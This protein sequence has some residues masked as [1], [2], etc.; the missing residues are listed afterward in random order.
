M[1]KTNASFKRQLSIYMFLV[2][3]L[4]F[5]GGKISHAE[6]EKKQD[7]I[8][9]IFGKNITVS[10]LWKG[11]PTRFQIEIPKKGDVPYPALKRFAFKVI[12][13]INAYGIRTYNIEAPPEKIRS[14]ERKQW[15]KEFPEKI[16][17][18][19]KET[20][21]RLEVLANLMEIWLRDRKRGE[22]ALKEAMR[23][24]PWLTEKEWK[25]FYNYIKTPEDLRKF[26][27]S[28]PRT[29]EEVIRQQY[30][31][32]SE[33]QTKLEELK[34]ILLLEQGKYSPI[35]GDLYS[36]YKGAFIVKKVKVIHIWYSSAKERA[37]MELLL[38]KALS[39]GEIFLY[40][41]KS[42]IKG[43]FEET[44]F[45]GSK[46]IESLPFWFIK[47]I[48]K[49]ENT[50]FSS[51]YPLY[52]TGWRTFSKIPFWHTFRVRE[53]IFKE[54]ISS[55]K[56][57][58]NKIKEKLYEKNLDRVYY[59]WILKEVQ[60]NLTIYDKRFQPALY[61]ITNLRDEQS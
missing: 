56:N 20:I 35:E 13:E 9:S 19:V 58:K 26:R 12:E 32:I 15:K 10:D 16:N 60:R 1:K 23:K 47:G 34:K 7:V 29:Q 45:S 51:P 43:G 2:I 61:I 54:N 24:N 57:V 11:V 48:S 52:R 33:K 8:A 30:K 3:Y 53:I 46:A 38:K 21:G 41:K 59:S 40:L 27:E 36:F 5:I 18:R 6:T 39:P 42:S 44:I 55:F 28:I 25:E 31:G 37:Q 50:V 17:K 14:W 4:F 49:G 22:K